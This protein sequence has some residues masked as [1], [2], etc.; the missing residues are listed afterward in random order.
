MQMLTVCQTPCSCWAHTPPSL[1]ALLHHTPTPP[2]AIEPTSLPPAARPLPPSG[3]IAAHRAMRGQRAGHTHTYTT[4]THTR[5]RSRTHT[6]TRTRTR[7]RTHTHTHTRTPGR[8]CL[9]VL[10]GQRQRPPALRPRVGALHA[11][12]RLAPHH[13]PGPGEPRACVHPQ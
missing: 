10:C 12:P 5:T 7:T 4:H 9:P 13:V 1:P 11:P 2:R 3:S 6:H 8:V